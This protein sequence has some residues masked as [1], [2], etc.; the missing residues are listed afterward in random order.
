YQFTIDFDK[1]ALELVDVQEG[2]AKADNFG[3][4][5]LNEG[6]ITTSW[7]GEA[8]SKQLF[9]LKFRALKDGQLSDLLKVDSRFTKAE[10]YN[11]N[12]ELLDVA[13]TFNGQTTA[14]D[15]ALY[16]N[17]PNP[18]NGETVIGFNLPE[19]GYAKLT[20]QDVAGKVLKVVDG[21]FGEGYNEVRVN[22]NDLGQTGVLY[23]TLETATETATKKMII[24]E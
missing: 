24:V 1:S 11:Q 22:S 17:T 19:A 8:S 6:A 13:L 10:A 3:F 15:F 14:T 5:L 4:T 23:Y 18:F 21:T 20:I 9:T 16:Q 7:N 2:V 12:G